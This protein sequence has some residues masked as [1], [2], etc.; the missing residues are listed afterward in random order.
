MERDQTIRLYLVSKLRIC[1]ARESN[2]SKFMRPSQLGQN[3]RCIS[4][5]ISLHCDPSNF[6]IISGLTSAV[7]TVVR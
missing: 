1:K 2:V 3:I 6:K 5:N 4:T 7:D